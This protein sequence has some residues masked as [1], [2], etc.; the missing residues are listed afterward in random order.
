MSP[1]VMVKLITPINN[2]D[3]TAGYLEQRVRFELT[4]LGFCRPLHWASLPPLHV[5]FNK[6]IKLFRAS[7]VKNNSHLI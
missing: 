3:G 1:S 7:S 5:Y 2:A 6:S 4:A